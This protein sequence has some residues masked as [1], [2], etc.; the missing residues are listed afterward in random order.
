MACYAKK[1]RKN[2]RVY[3]VLGDGE[4]QEGLVWEA[5][6]AAAH[7]KL[8]NLIVLYD[9]NDITIE[10]STE[11]AFSE[12]VGKRYES[13][14][15]KVYD[16]DGHDVKQI[17]KNI[18]AAK[19]VKGLPKII[20]CKTHIAYNAPTLQDKSA[21]HGSPL[22]AEE[23]RNTKIK[24]GF[25]ENESF[26]IPEDVKSF[27]NQVIE[28]KRKDYDFWFLNFKKWQEKNPEKNAELN[29]YLNKE[30]PE[31]LAKELL[32]DLP[33]KAEAT[34]VS[35]GNSIQKI[36]K[37]IPF[38]VGGSADLEPSVKCH[39][40]ASSSVCASDYSGRNLHFG[41]R[42]HAMGA[43]MNG[44][45]LSGLFV[46][47][48]ATFLVFSDYMKGAVRLSAIMGLQTVYVFTH[49]SIFLGEDGPTHQPIEHIGA[50]RLIPNIKIIRPADALETACAWLYALNSKKAPTALILSRQNLPQLHANKDSS[51]VSEVLR[52]G[53]ILE[54]SSKTSPD[55]I[56]VASGSEVHLAVEA[57]KILLSSGID[58]RI[59]SMPSIEIFMEQNS[60]YREGVLP[61]KAKVIAIEA[62]NTRDWDRFVANGGLFIGLS[63]FGHSA[64]AEILAEKYGFTGKQI[65]EKIKQHLS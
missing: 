32:E 4:I 6:M 28:Q 16:V 10:G 50:L 64:P 17:C 1:E 52:G 26:Y 33:E 51:K 19:K 36:A 63:G 30:V 34:R 18:E 61:S 29:M 9:S 24:L 25:P 27:C 21:S 47:H 12:N 53:Y 43:I 56:I 40:K 49:D 57:R 13:Y 39:I 45:A 8:D 11:L 59:V 23:I 54:S 31:A 35:S 41:I 55:V 38:T 20:I 15:W 2:F 65:A 60:S 14:G 5:A 7:L 22:G 62:A 44:M 46:P 58:A 48:G 3:A 42:E 37:H